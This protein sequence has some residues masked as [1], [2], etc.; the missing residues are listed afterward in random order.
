MSKFKFFQKNDCLTE[1][2]W[3]FDSDF[4]QGLFQENYK[5]KYSLTGS[6]IYNLVL[7]DNK[8]YEIDLKTT[9]K[10]LD[11]DGKKAFR[12]ATKDTIVNMI[13]NKLKDNNVDC[14][15]NSGKFIT[16]KHFGNIFKIEITK[17]ATMPN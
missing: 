15:V 5:H 7:I 10:L 16:F 1:Y 14:T 4:L 17:K 13:V 11:N 12:D 8:I 6:G 9:T 3:A 2:E